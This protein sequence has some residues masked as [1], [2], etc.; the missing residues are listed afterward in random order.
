MKN[1]L[2]TGGAGF[3]G[4]HLADNLFKTGN[5][6]I[7]ILD[8]LSKKTHSSDW[9]KYLNKNYKLILGD[10]T[11][12]K[13]LLKALK[14]INIVFHLAAELDLVPDYQKFMNVN[15]GSTALIFELIKKN[16]LDVEKVLIASTQFVYGNGLWTNKD[17]KK[18]FPEMREIDKRM[19][20]DF[21]QNDEKLNYNYCNETQTV[22]PPNHY[23]LSKYFQEK[24][25][26]NL[27]KLNGIDVRVLRYSII[28]GIRQSIK[29]TYSGALRTLCYFAILNK[30]Y[31]TFE[32]NNSLRDFTPVYDAVQ[33][34]RLV[35]EKGKAFEIYNISNSTPFSVYELASI[36]SKEFSI[37]CKFSTKIEWRHGDIRHAIS[38]N[39]KLL[40]LGFKPKFEETDVVK[41][42]VNWFKKQD[43]D[44]NRFNKTQI[45]MRKNGQII[46][47]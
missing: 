31:S 38:D 42:Y 25:A 19:R 39:S 8:N 6:N 14:S 1:V 26:L 23:A 41:E 5:Y 12:K 37:E 33:A 34:S 21:Y 9:P 11:D 2:I 35:L 24:I 47:F 10:V 45:K 43:L 16:K 3:I 15:V 27:G 40:D 30:E 28:H 46:S 44:F 18:F 20:W 36:I 32:D 4:S 13:I 22:S 17:G 29:N 7:T